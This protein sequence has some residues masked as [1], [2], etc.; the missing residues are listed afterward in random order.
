VEIIR[1]DERIEERI[2]ELKTLP[3]E[4]SEFVRYLAAKA[5]NRV[6]KSPSSSKTAA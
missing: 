6:N 3:S 5:L 4:H 1:P 2:K